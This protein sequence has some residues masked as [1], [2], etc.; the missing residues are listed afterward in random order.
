MTYYCYCNIYIL[1][2]TVYITVT[3]LNLLP[4]WL[5][6]SI[7][8]SVFHLVCHVVGLFFVLFYF[9]QIYPEMFK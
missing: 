4:R 1:L 5:L 2:Y 9:S 8:T 6:D 3:A 7:M